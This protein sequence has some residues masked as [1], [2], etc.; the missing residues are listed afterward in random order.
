VAPGRRGPCPVDGGPDD[1]L[2]DGAPLRRYRVVASVPS[3]WRL[4]TATHNLIK[5]HNHWIATDTGYPPVPERS[6]PRSP[7]VP[8]ETRSLPRTLPDSLG[9]EQVD[10]SLL[11]Q[12]SFPHGTGIRCTRAAW[13]QSRPAQTP[14]RPR[15]KPPPTTHAATLPSP[16][17]PSCPP[18][19]PPQRETILHRH[20][21]V[22]H[23]T[24]QANAAR[25]AIRNGYPNRSHRD[26]PSS[27]VRR[28]SLD[29]LTS[30]WAWLGVSGGPARTGRTCRVGGHIQARPDAV[31]AQGTSGA[32]H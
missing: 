1:Q 31:R 24:V 12:T 6:A 15:A 27:A 8:A 23:F 17:A 21:A 30:G 19:P 14:P 28:K 5:L 7:S 29:V 4:I 26:K 3:E 18:P 32:V 10:A 11:A 2:R 9:D 25:L 16:T 20:A 22:V 13:H